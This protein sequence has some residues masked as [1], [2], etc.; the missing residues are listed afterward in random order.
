MEKNGQTINLDGFTFV[1]KLLSLRAH[2][3]T[4][5][6]KK[7]LDTYITGRD[8]AERKWQKISGIRQMEKEKTNQRKKQKE[9]ECDI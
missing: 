4:Q 2:K 5:R 8:T 9:R 3:K 7:W 6:R 1:F